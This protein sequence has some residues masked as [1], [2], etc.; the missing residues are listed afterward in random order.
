MLGGEGRGK[1]EVKTDTQIYISLDIYTDFL[2]NISKPDLYEGGQE[3]QVWVSF[4]T[5]QVVRGHRGCT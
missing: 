4:I 3:A 2:W 5:Q 1:V